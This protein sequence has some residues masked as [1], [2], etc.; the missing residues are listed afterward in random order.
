MLEI[1]SQT[2]D[3]SGD[4]GHANREVV[5]GKALEILSRIHTALTTRVEEQHDSQQTAPELEDS[6][7]EDAKRR[8]MLHA[9]LDLISL[10]GIYPSLSSGVGIPLQQRV[11]SVL[12]AG[13]IATQGDATASSVPQNAALLHRIMGVL[14]TITLD[15]KPSIQP[16]IRGRILSDII[17]GT[18]DIAFNPSYIPNDRPK[19]QKA[20]AKIIDEYV[21]KVEIETRN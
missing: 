18:A 14:L 5:I 20:F 16:L 13:V 12:P 4:D 21:G 7:L 15:E 3:T 8:R 19:F 17:S 10:E 2:P 1:L 6:N 11:V 9:L